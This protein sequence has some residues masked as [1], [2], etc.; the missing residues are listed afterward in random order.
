MTTDRFLIPYYAR[1]ATCSNVSFRAR[2]YR[3]VYSESALAPAALACDGVHCAWPTAAARALNV[4][5]GP[6]GAVEAVEA[7][8]ADTVR[9]A[10]P[11]ARW[12]TPGRHN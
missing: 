7:L 1:D 6:P 4:S 12:R 10:D 3:A 5:G 2:Q 11:A 9:F 8:F